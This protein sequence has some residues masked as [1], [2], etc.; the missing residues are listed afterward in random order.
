MPLYRE[1]AKQLLE[2]L[3]TLIKDPM[4]FKR[5]LE[6]QQ[7]QVLDAIKKLREIFSKF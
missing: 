5:L 6:S 4:E 7:A 3:E 1:K 2:E